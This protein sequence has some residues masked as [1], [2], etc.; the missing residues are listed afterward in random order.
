MVI[1]PIVGVY[2]PI[3]R[4]PIKGGMTIPYIA[5]FDHGTMFVF[6]EGN[7]PWDR[8]SN[9]PWKT[10]WHRRW[11]GDWWRWQLAIA[12]I[13]PSTRRQQPLTMYGIYTWTV[14]YMKTIKINQMEVNIPY[15]SL[16]GYDLLH[17]L[18]FC[19]S[20]E[21]SELL[22]PAQGQGTASFLCIWEL[23]LGGA[24]WVELVVATQICLEFS[25]RNPGVS[26]SNLTCAYF[27]KGLVQPP[28]SDDL[29]GW[30]CFHWTSV[31]TEPSGRC[32]LE[33]SSC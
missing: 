7:Q 5:T 24:V 28:T 15:M 2:I 31:M 12:F 16:M 14:T 4:I 17:R 19:F 10:H 6:R 3:A 18:F 27:S 30:P 20:G 33:R 9:I 29:T 1:N 21:Y 13:N 22:C 8:S 11:S 26:W 32:P 23:H 25:P